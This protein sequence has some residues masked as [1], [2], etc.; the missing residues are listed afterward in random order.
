[1]A[2]FMVSYDLKTPGKDYT[3]LH[4]AL[5]SCGAWRQYLDSTLLLSTPYKNAKD[6]FDIIEP[7]MDI[8]DRV[9]IVRIAAEASG[10][11]PREAWEWINAQTY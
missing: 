7:H 6:I 11:L 1:M 4:D 3:D 10:S 5:K 2:V 8:N 9:L